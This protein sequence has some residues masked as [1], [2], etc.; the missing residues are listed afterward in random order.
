MNSPVG[1]PRVHR[2]ADAGPALRGGAQHRPGR[3]VDQGGQVGPQVLRRASSSTGKRIGVVGLGPHRP[4]GGGALPRPR[5][6]G[7][8]PTTRS[9]RRRSRRRCT[10]RSLPLDELLQT[11]RLRHPAHHAHRGDAAPHR[12]R[13]PCREGQAG[14]AHRERRARRADRRGGAAGGARQRPRRRRRA[15]RARPGAAGGLAARPAPARGGHAARRRRHRRGAGARGHRH[16]GPGARLPEGRRHPAGRQLLLAVAATSTTRCARPWT[17]P[18]RLGM[19]LAQVCPGTWSASRSA[20]TATCGRS[21]SSRS[22][23]R[24]CCGVLKRAPGEGVTARQRAARPPGS[25]ASTSSS[26]PRRSRVAFANL[27]ALRLKTSERDCSVAG[28]LFGRNHLRLVDVDGVEVDAI[29]Q[30]HLLLVKNDDT[31]GRRRPH[32]HAA[33]RARR[34]TSRA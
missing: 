34:S 26:P 18:Q 12:Q 22:C 11:L 4:R 27:M 31:P 1:Q 10:C 16:R 13:R 32:R 21:T 2:R 19:F 15:R 24:R 3:R 23:P 20:S 8:R 28:T 33:R 29:P 7:R 6:G 17:S 5:H 14:R 25:A 30:G 9:C